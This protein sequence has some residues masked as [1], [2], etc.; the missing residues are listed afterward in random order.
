MNDMETT[1]KSFHRIGCMQIIGYLLILGFTVLGNRNKD[2]QDAQMRWSYNIAKQET[3]VRSLGQKEPPEEEMAT[4]SSIL[5]CRIPWTEE[6]DRLWSIGS[7]R[8][9]QDR[10]DS[11]HAL[12]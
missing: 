3:R 1:Q 9:R 6:P 8:V 7:Q 2:R 4:Q 12:S 10:S 5:A 11:T